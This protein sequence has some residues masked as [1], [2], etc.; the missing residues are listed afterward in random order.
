MARDRT[1]QNTVF[2]YGLMLVKITC[3][4]NWIYASQDAR[5]MDFVIFKTLYSPHFLASFLLFMTVIA[6]KFV[7]GL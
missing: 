5:K 3:T 4:S 7:L 1:R 6:S 2:L